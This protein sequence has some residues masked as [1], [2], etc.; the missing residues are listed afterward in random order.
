MQNNVH[1]KIDEGCHSI[2]SLL[3]K[4]QIR[5]GL[6]R[7]VIFRPFRKYSRWRWRLTAV[8]DDDFDKQ[9]LEKARVHCFEIVKWKSNI[10]KIHIRNELC[11][12]PIHIFHEYRQTL[13]ILYTTIVADDTVMFQSLVQVDFT[14]KCLHFLHCSRTHCSS[15][16][17]FHGH[18]FTCR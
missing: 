3:S 14:V 8:W 12:H 13:C 1:L 2:Q 18:L 15:L 9:M 4:S 17:T 6:K 5:K 16:N 11:T 7:K 10:S